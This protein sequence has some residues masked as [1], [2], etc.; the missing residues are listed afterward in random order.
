MVHSRILGV[1]GLALN[2]FA[3]GALRTRFERP[4]L[5][6]CCRLPRSLVLVRHLY[7]LMARLSLLILLIVPDQL[8]RLVLL[9]RLSLTAL[10]RVVIIWLN[11]L[12]SGLLVSFV[13]VLL[14]IL[15]ARPLQRI[16]LTLLGLLAR[17]PLLGF[18]SVFDICLY[19]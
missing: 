7:V 14:Q 19:L 13:S 6:L 15:H 17:G 10:A 11:T 9:H 1:L 2:H 5:L 18:A 3:R 4:H 12:I 16:A 8:G